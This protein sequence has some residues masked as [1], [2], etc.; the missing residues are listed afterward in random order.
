MAKILERI[1][2]DQ[3]CDYLQEHSLLTP[4]QSGFRPGH[5]TQDVLIKTMDDWHKELDS[6]HIVLALFVDLSKA[7]NTIDHK[8]LLEKLDMFFG[9]RN[10]EKM[11]FQAYLENR[12]KRVISG[13]SSSSWLVPRLGAPQGSILGPLLFVMFVNDLPTVIRMN[14]VNMYADNTT[15]YYGGANVNDSIQVLQEDAQSVLQWFDCNGLTVNLK[16]TNLM[17]LGIR[18][19]EKEFRDSSMSLDGVELLPKASVKYLGVELDS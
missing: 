4:H 1:V 3:L 8:L 2:F 14:S 19:R 10:E 11:W 6:D 7:F 18:R 5:S 13:H 12:L 16:K 9:V 15:L 17:I